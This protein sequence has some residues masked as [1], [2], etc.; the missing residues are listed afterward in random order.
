MPTSP[1]RRRFLLGSAAATAA[2]ASLDLLPGSVQK[3]LA[4]TSVEPLSSLDQVEH[5]VMLM[6]ENRSFDHYFGSLAG[7]RGF[8]DPDALQLST[9]NSVFYQPDPD[10]P[11]GYELPFRLVS[12]RTSAPSMPSLSHAWSAQHESWNGG[13]MDN[14]LPAHRA[15]D[16]NTDG[17]LTMGYFTRS[18]L[19]FHYALADAFTI[20]D[21]YHCSVMGPT[22]P[23]RLFFMA[24]GIDPAGLGGGPILGDSIPEPLTYLTYPEA[25]QAAGVSWRVY[26]ESN[27]DGCNML[28][29]FANFVNAP[30]TSPLYQNG[31]LSRPH[32]AFR[33]DVR[34]GALP[35]VSWIVPPS[36]SIEHPNAMPG[37][38]AEYIADFLDAL[39]STPEVWA[40]TVLFLTYDENDGL[41]DHVSPPTAPQ[42]TPGEWI[43]AADA[44]GTDGIDGPVGLG[45]RVP[46][47][48]IS[49]WTVGGWV[50]S[51]VFD[52]TSMLRF[53]EQRFGVEVPNL[54]AWRRQ[55]VGDLTSVLRHRPQA[56]PRLP[57]PEPV[58]RLE[59]QEVATLPAPVVPAV[60]A[61]PSQEPARVALNL[62]A[63]PQLVLPGRTS[64]VTATVANNGVSAAR[65]AGVSRLSLGLTT[66]QGWAVTARTA[67]TFEEVP[68]GGR[69][70]ASWKI[71]VPDNATP[72]T[73]A[74]VNV[75]A[76]YQVSAGGQAQ[77]ANAQAQVP[78]TV[79]STLAQAFNNV[80]ASDDSSGIGDFNGGGYSYSM[81]ALAA[82]GLS[83][84]AAVSY[85]G[86]TFTWPSAPGGQPGNVLVGGQAVLVSGSGSTLGFL[87]ASCDNDEGGYGTVFY[88]DGTTS[89][90]WLYLDNYWD[91]PDDNAVVATMPYCNSKG[92]KVAHTVYLFYYGVPVDPGKTVWAVTL[93]TGT[94]APAGST[95]SGMHVFAVGVGG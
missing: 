73:M 75:Q 62:D 82:A 60:Q 42:G 5:V 94:L 2:A 91:A 48:V 64:L 3:A 43:T 22:W 33:D 14:W 83:P 93:P 84:G 87:G 80:G 68:S 23:N 90:Y 89:S 72:G 51:E 8:S 28:P 41:F 40:K 46:M 7:V 59:Q 70:R 67:T 18:D 4:A 30:T 66:S 63:S 15:A 92:T 61:M 26:Q 71:A 6:M 27:S 21:A 24:G 45:F 52:H 1:T 50:S 77:S 34:S 88:T 53:V 74:P 79:P 10:N 57:D 13:A 56:S 69:V 31:L 12:A 36:L 19:P 78:V 29:H 39:A 55:T 44:S 95:I 20:C 9:G 17:P 54:S 32:S 85:D 16:G 86:V 49:P 25:L 76:S 58:S 35:Q 37:P 47:I 38:G 81:Q 65:P 11:D